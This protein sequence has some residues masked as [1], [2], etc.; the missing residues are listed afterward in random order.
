MRKKKHVKM[1]HISQE[2]CLFHSNESI[3]PNLFHYRH[4]RERVLI[5]TEV[6]ARF[7]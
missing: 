7:S 1:P 2:V 3:F 5:E 4:V 6:L